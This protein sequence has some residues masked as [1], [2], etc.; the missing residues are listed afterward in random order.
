MVGECALTHRATGRS[1][2]K[3]ARNPGGA[4]RIKPPS[5][6]KLAHPTKASALLCTRNLLP[7]PTQRTNGW[8][9]VGRTR[10]AASVRE[11]EPSGW[12]RGP[13]YNAIVKFC[14]TTVFFL[15]GAT[16]FT[17][18]V[19]TLSPYLLSQRPILAATVATA[20][21]IFL[22]SHAEVQ[23][24]SV[25]AGWGGPLEVQGIRLVQRP[26]PG[27]GS[28][29]VTGQVL[30]CGADRIGTVDSFFEFVK[31]AAFHSKHK[32]PVDV[33]VSSP[34][35][36]LC[37]DGNGVVPLMKF[38]EDTRLVPKPLPEAVSPLSH[39]DW[40]GQSHEVA[41]NDVASGVAIPFTGEIT[42]DWVHL[43]LTEGALTLPSNFQ[44]E[45]FATKDNNVHIEVLQGSQ[46]IR[47]G[48]GYM[49]PLHDE[50]IDI[51]AIGKVVDPISIRIDSPI[52]ATSFTGWKTQR[53]YTVLDA[54]VSVILRPTPDVVS[55]LLKRANPLLNDVVN[56]KLPYDNES[57]GQG[58]DQGPIQ[59]S[60]SP[61]KGILPASQMTVQVNPIRLGLGK[62]SLLSN[63]LL[64]SLLSVVGSQAFAGAGES[65]VGSSTEILDATVGAF[66]VQLWT[67]TG[68]VQLPRMDLLLRVVGLE[69]PLKLICWG[70]VNEP[71]V[72]FTV[73]VTSETVQALVPGALGVWSPAEALPPGYAIPI[74]ITGSLSKPTI[75]NAPKAIADLALLVLEARAREALH[76]GGSAAA[77]VKASGPRAS[78]TTPPDWL[79]RDLSRT[80]RGIDM[81]QVPDGSRDTVVP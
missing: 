62:G 56:V 22:P 6:T 72:A 50:N 61:H 81:V 5:P 73:G 52:L 69:N 68:R 37:R 53:G 29:S 49:V 65:M 79:L 9:R 17:A 21:A 32:D 39:E 43:A 16:A 10:V 45:S 3:Y 48:R 41:V 67:K 11:E 40:K 42:N 64:N 78:T 59:V 38:L 13:V 12:L 15:L 35:L 26:R 60:I 46:A 80:A 19:L 77:N 30:L 76:G 54:P 20:N 33:I 28:G 51:N 24:D 75:T 70:V 18:S 2:A 58:R 55:S 66:S 31:R 4:W 34:R 7:T 23:I 25:S 14:R 36:N 8:N 44:V 27:S 74:R 63:Q 1:F 71:S 47:E 57:H